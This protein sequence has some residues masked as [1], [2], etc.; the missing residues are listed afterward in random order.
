M[1]QVEDDHETNFKRDDVFRE[2][3][4]KKKRKARYHS[5][6]TRSAQVEV[7]TP[8]KQMSSI[9]MQEL[10]NQKPEFDLTY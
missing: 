10:V 6:S 8:T 2:S 1:E 3:R 7:N 9:I 5:G 4:V